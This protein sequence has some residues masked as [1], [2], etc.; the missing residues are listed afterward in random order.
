MLV[1]STQ[2]CE[3]LVLP[4]Q[5]FSLVNSPPALSCVSK[6]VVQYTHKQ[7]VRGVWGSRPQTD[8]HLPQ[9]PFTGKFFQMTFC[10]AFYEYCIT[11]VVT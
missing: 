4:L 8:K 6:Y 1:F 3:L 7:C 10:I 11:T 9:N 5:P 2:L